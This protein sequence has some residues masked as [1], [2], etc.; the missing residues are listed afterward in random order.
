M[1]ATA[2]FIST[3]AVLDRID[4]ALLQRFQASLRG[5]LIRSEDFEY[6]DARSLYNA[7]IDKRP[8]LIVRCA[9]VADVIAAVNFAREQDLL[10]AIRGG[11]HNGAGLGS[12]D[13]GLV[14]DLSLMKG[15]RVDPEAREVRVE[16]GCVWSEVDHATHAFGL[17][18][19]CGIIGST[20]VAGLT[21]GGGLGY[22]SRRFGL[23]IDNLL[24]ADMVLANGR[25]VSVSATS[26]P[27]LFWAIRGGGGNFGVVTSFHFRAHPVDNVVAGP[28]FWPLEKAPEVIAWFQ[29][30]L[31]AAPRELG[32]WF[33]I[34]TIP[35]VAPFPPELHLRT[36][37]GIVWCYSG[38]MEQA[39]E[40]LA[41]IRAYGPPLFTGLMQMPFPALQTAFDAR[42][43]KGHQWYW[44]ADF[45]TKISD[46]AAR[47]HLKHGR[48]VPT[49]QST[50]HLYP[51]DG[52]VQDVGPNETA[53]GYRHARFAEVIVGVDPDPAKSE[54]LTSW[55][56]EYWEDLHP[57]SAGGAY[58]N[59]MMEEGSDR[60]RDAYGRNYDRLAE[61]KR[62]Y[63]PENLFRVNQNIVPAG[64]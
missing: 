23:T 50:M 63:D 64:R 4:P 3:S 30:F 60:V 51:I 53:W 41:P 40:V 8:A 44:K 13:D 27:D 16:A 1:S 47:L 6:D 61:I 17:A 7:M 62:R 20:G 2:S 25:F 5:Q 32:G 9:D 46:E 10:L 42:Y 36:I 26:H 19:P 11:G 58:V 37:C 21:L 45:F 12:C 31:A 24:G 22:L 29:E 34:M 54:Q 48:N 59:M 57:H 14:I 43:P 18:V 35:P 49:P 39:E 15:I 28:T 38:P 55:A 56:R 52:A 33:G